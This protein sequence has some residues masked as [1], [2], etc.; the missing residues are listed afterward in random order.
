MIQR[1]GIDPGSIAVSQHALSYATAFHRC[2]TCE[3]KPDCLRWL[4]TAGES[5]L[6]APRFCPNIDIFLE[7]RVDSLHGHTAHAGS[8]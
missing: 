7:L 6:L 8:A 1:L 2:E 3:H 5:R 4:E